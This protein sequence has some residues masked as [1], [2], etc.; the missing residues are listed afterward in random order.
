MGDLGRRTEIMPV[1]DSHTRIKIFKFSLVFPF[2]YP[3]LIHPLGAYEI[4]GF[5]QFIMNATH[6][7]IKWLALASDH[8]PNGNFYLLGNGHYI[9]PL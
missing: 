6:L 5:L 8:C 3:I 1:E 4:G 2:V 9:Q 7:R